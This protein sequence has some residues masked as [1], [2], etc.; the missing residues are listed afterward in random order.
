[1]NMSDVWLSQPYK[2]ITVFRVSPKHN[3][4][5]ITSGWQIYRWKAPRKRHIFGTLSLIIVVV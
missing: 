5:R 3:I 4:E 2:Y 1:M